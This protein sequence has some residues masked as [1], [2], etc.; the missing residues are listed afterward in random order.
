MG[1]KRTVAPPELVPYIHEMIHELA[2]NKFRAY[3]VPDNTPS[4]IEGKN[5]W[6][7]EVK[8]PSWYSKLRRKYPKNRNRKKW[9]KAWTRVGDADSIIDRRWILSALKQLKHKR[10]V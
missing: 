5:K 2:L 3:Q 6:Q 7:S 4:A 8:N 9:N 1:K 10:K